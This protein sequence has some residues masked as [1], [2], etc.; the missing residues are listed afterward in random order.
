VA[1]AAM[2]DG[3]F[4]MMVPFCAGAFLFYGLLYKSYLVPRW[5]AIW[6][7]AAMIPVTVGTVC[8][9]LGIKISFVLFAPYI[10]FEFI[11]GIWILIFGIRDE[12]I[13]ALESEPAVAP[14]THI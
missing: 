7:L 14:L 8:T 1:Y 6:G 9:V 2:D 3:A 4:L 12:A 10:P 11:L 13:R 5:L